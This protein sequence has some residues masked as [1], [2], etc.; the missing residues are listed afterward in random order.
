MKITFLGTAA[1]TSYPLPFCLC[2]Y[3]KEAKSNRG[4]DIRKRSSVLIN[5]DLIIDMGPDFV[6]SCFMYNQDPALIRYALQT[7]SHSDHFDASIFST[8][9]PEYAVKNVPLLNLYG[10]RAT[11]NKM[12]EMLRGEGYVSDLFDPKD[13]ERLNIKVFPVTSLETFKAGMYEVTALPTDHDFLV[14]S[15]LY[16]IND[17][18][19]T[20]FYATDTDILMEEV[21]EGV[22]NKDLKFNCVILDQTYGHNIDRKGHLNAD[23][24]VGLIERLKAENLL[25]KNAQILATHI[26]HE[27]NPPHIKLSVYAKQH[28]YEIAYDGLI[29]NS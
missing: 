26:S 1:A 2:E 11:I 29:L 13:Q 27:G 8:R 17:G 18:D 4:K 15:L 28:G 9:I 7:H 14:E 3:C 21:W 10:S 22:H 6:T 24:V 19:F 23:K 5:N 25:I 20:L 16:V 12:S